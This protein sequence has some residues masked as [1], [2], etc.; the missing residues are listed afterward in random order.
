MAHKYSD[1]LMVAVKSTKSTALSTKPN[2]NNQQQLLCHYHCRPM[3][4]P[5]PPP[6]APLAAAACLNNCNCNEQ[7]LISCLDASNILAR[8]PPT[9]STPTCTG[10]MSSAK[11][12][13]LSSSK[14]SKYKALFPDKLNNNNNGNN[15]GGLN[16]DL[17][18]PLGRYSSSATISCQ[19]HYTQQQPPL[20]SL[21]N[22]VGC[23]FLPETTSIPMSGHLSNYNHHL[24]HHHHHHLQQ[25]Q[26]LHH[27]LF[28]KSSTLSTT[29]KD[30]MEKRKLCRLNNI[31]YSK[32]NKIG[33]F[34]LQDD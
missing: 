8:L 28:S 12:K 26:Q 22:G 3:S 19:C 14:K 21:N 32:N 34:Y 13:H 18:Y 30:L 27:E 17:K 1:A 4:T 10:C 20:S 6:Q 23:C 31:L 15:N 11:I 29:A 5:L 9:A 25:Q 2:S 16:L 7:T 24:H 33:K